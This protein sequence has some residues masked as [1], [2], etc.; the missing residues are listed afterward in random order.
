MSSVFPHCVAAGIVLNAG[1]LDAA[2]LASA[3]SQHVPF[4]YETH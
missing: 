4:K 1:V 3:R 2:L